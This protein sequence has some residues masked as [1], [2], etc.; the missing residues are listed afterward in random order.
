MSR[1]GEAVNKGGVQ[2]AT[3]ETRLDPIA[4]HRLALNVLFDAEIKKDV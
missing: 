4:S 3:K 1:T 2:M